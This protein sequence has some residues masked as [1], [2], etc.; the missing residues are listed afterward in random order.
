MNNAQWEDGRKKWPDRN[1]NLMSRYVVDEDTCVRMN[2]LVSSIWGW[3]FSM[4]AITESIG[5][6]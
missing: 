4:N 1:I 5:E 6:C 2:R 3:Q